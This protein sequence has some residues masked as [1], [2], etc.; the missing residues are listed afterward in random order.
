MKDGRVVAITGAG[1]GIGR[2]IVDRFLAN[3]DRVIDLDRAKSSLEELAT[4]RNAGNQ[5]STACVDI[6]DE[7]AVAEFAKHIN[8]THG[9]VDVLVNCA[10]SYPV[11]SFEQMTQEQWL[12]MI[13]INLTGTFRVTHA[14]LPL[15]KSR[16][17]GRIINIG[18]ASVFE[19][20]VG[21]THYVSAKAGIVGFTRSLA[22]EVGDYGITV[23]IVAP[24]LT[25][26]EPVLNGMPQE[27]IKTQ[28]DLRAIKRDEHPQ[29]LA[30]PVF[31][32]CS[33]DAD[34]VSGQMLVV[35]GGK[36]KH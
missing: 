36:I 17:W 8:Q 24:G 9:H 35:D 29:D 16:G 33:P 4:S 12:E 11:V 26:T 18:S 25:L 34:F 2:K 20:V 32:L 22:M 1:G 10:G 6:T 21:Q 30:G 5:L 15:M 7:Y 3:G 23:N 27:L 28:V 14:L 19:G 31:L 13:A